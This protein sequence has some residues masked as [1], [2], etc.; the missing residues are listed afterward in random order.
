MAGKGR[1]KTR[2]RLTDLGDIANN[3]NS[4]AARAV[5]ETIF[6]VLPVWFRTEAEEIATRA[7]RGDVGG[8]TI[9]QQAA[10]SIAHYARTYGVT[11]GQLE[12]RL[13]RPVAQWTESDLGLLRVLNSEMA[14]GEKSVDDEF[15]TPAVTADEIQSAAPTLDVP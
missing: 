2:E 1:D 12:T 7:L 11:K 13:S 10:D 6:T 14:R 4:V 8:K 9:A 15:A 5:R 3:N